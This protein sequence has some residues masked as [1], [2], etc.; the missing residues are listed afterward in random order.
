[1]SLPSSLCVAV[2]LLSVTQAPGTR[3]TRFP[4]PHLVKGLG[5]T[6][7]Q[8]NFSALQ[9]EIKTLSYQGRLRE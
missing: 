9:K 2:L 4:K 1:M 7:Q 8:T 5:V 6:V 3:G